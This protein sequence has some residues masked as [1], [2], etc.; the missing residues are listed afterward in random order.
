MPDGKRLAWILAVTLTGLGVCM[1]A[2]EPPWRPIPSIPQ[3]LWTFSFEE[4]IPSKMI[5]PG[6]VVKNEPKAAIA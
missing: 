5:E 3:L 1:A 2:E 4:D 6:T